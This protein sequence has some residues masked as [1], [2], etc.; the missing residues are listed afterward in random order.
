MARQLLNTREAAT[1]M[2]M[3]PG[4]LEVWRS[5]GRGPRYRKIGWKVFYTVEDIQEFID[6][7]LIRTVD[8]W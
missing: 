4:T 3:S 5:K 7:Q 6:S 2:R 1:E 8:S